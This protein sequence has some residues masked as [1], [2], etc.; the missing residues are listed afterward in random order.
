MGSSNGHQQW[1]WAA[2]MGGSNGRHQWAAAMGS[3]NG[4]LQWAAAMGCRGEGQQGMSIPPPE[5]AAD[6]A[7]GA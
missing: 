6:S 1:A 2:A 7:E 4:Q 3:S 5:N